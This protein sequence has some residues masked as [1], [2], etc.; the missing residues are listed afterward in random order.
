MSAVGEHS[1]VQ[2]GQR[3]PGMDVLIAM[4]CLPSHLRVCKP[5]GLLVPTPGLVLGTI[6]HWEALN[7]GLPISTSVHYIL[8]GS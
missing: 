5:W 4:R 6:A 1:G 3:C 2:L 7:N 8:L